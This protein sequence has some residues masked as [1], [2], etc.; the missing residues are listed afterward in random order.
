MLR[1]EQARTGKLRLALE[2]AEAELDDAYAA[3][4]NPDRGLL[5]KVEELQEENG[6]LKAAVVEL[7]EELGPL[8]TLEARMQ[9]VL[10][11]GDHE[12]N[13]RHEEP[14][15]GGPSREGA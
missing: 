5:E 11:G 2:D 14:R 6:A 8:R 1:Q 13:G 12:L 7:E 3:A 10:D 15:G 4:D 9:A